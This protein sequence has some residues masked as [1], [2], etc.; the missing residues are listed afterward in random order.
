[1]SRRLAANREK[2][3]DVLG[4]TGVHGAERAAKPWTD[5]W[6]YSVAKGVVGRH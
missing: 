4:L 5:Q 6:P 3:T 1:M 2:G